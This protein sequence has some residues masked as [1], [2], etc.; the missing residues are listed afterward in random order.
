MA[1]NQSILAHGFEPVGEQVFE[2]LWA[3]GINLG[4]FAEQD[5]P[6]FPHLAKPGG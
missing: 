6:T 1:R 2:K 5:L 3:A 4:G